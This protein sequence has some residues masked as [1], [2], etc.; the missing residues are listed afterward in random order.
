MR[1]LRPSP[2]TQYSRLAWPRD[3]TRCCRLLAASSSMSPPFPLC[4]FPGMRHNVT[5]AFLTRDT[6][7][8]PHS[9]VALGHRT[10][11]DCH[12]IALPFLRCPGTRRR[13]L[14][15]GT[16]L[17]ASRV[18]W[19]ATSPFARRPVAR[20]AMFAPPPYLSFINPCRRGKRGVRCGRE[21]RLTM[22]MK[23]E[24]VLARTSEEREKILR[25]LCRG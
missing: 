13:P 14:P 9:C 16:P 2:L 10:S 19:E 23:D 3:A 18:F 11:H 15:H 17:P 25:G 6:K 20:D 21:A 5:T 7:S 1:H 24:R 22:K 8:P 4:A 12:D